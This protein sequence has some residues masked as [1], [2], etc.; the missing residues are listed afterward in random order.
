M[1]DFGMFI[2][3]AEAVILLLCLYLGTHDVM[4]GAGVL[5]IPASVCA[6]GSLAV[7]LTGEPVLTEILVFSASGTLFGIY[8]MLAVYLA[9]F[10]GN[11]YSVMHNRRH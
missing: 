6:V 2:L 9:L 11:M 5:F 4:E 8:Y 3:I 1:T 10:R 7:L